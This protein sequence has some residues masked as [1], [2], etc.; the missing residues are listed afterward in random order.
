[1]AL[2]RGSEAGDRSARHSL[3][4]H[5][6][7]DESHVAIRG[8]VSKRTSVAKTVKAILESSEDWIVER[9][10][11]IP[12]PALTL[13]LGLAANQSLVADHC[14]EIYSIALADRVKERSGLQFSSI[15][16]GKRHNDST[17]IAVGPAIHRAQLADSV[18]TD[19]TTR[20]SYATPAFAHEV[21]EAAVTLRKVIRPNVPISL[22][23]S[24]VTGL[25][26][27]W[28]RLWAPTVSGVFALK[29]TAGGAISSGQVVEL[30]LDHVSI[31]E[32]LGHRVQIAISAE[33]AS[34]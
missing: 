5:A 14:L 2:G 11:T 34:T 27:T 25:P 26:R 12:K 17:V 1:M 9:A 31:G 30:Q 8:A 13:E 10:Q 3:L 32:S 28:S 16:L 4:E 6:F 23:L 22:H 19:L 15:R 29:P 21:A 33:P 20:R 18:A 24:F 7:V